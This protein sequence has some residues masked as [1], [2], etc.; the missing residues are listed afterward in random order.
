[1]KS[2]VVKRETKEQRKV[3]YANSKTAKSQQTCQSVLYLKTVQSSIT[4]CPVFI[5]RESYPLFFLTKDENI[6]RANRMITEQFSL[7]Q[8]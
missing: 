1:M 5:Q 4:G 2:G 8:G 6:L 7:I 3:L